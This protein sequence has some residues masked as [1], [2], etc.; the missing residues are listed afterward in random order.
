VL[1]RRSVLK[2]IGASLFTAAARD[3]QATA[4]GESRAILNEGFNWLDRAI[5]RQMIERIA[6]AGFNVLVTCVWHGTG[7]AWP[8]KVAPMIENY[9]GSDP[10]AYLLE[11]AARRGIEVHA[12]FTVAL[13]QRDFLN[14]LYDLGTP[15]QKFELHR[16]EF[17]EFICSTMLEFVHLYPVQGINLDYVRTGG[18]SLSSFAVQDYEEKTGRSLLLDRGLLTPA[19]RT[20]LQNWQEAAITEIIRNVSTGSRSLRPGILVSVDAAP[21]YQ[22]YRLEGQNSIRW[23]E[24]GL[25]D[26]LYSMNYQDVL[27]VAG[28]NAIRNAMIRP[29]ALVPVVSNYLDSRGEVKSRDGHAMASLIE[30]SRSVSRDNGVAVYLYNMLDDAQVL[31]LRNTVFARTV[32]PRWV[33]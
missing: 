20:S 7:A 29:A 2:S 31:A 24:E 16:R 8:S 22:P 30:Q 19:A 28:L 15:A 27:D 6:D 32:I 1:S 11:L 26:V 25:I 13:R 23:A 21:W 10:F 18:T 33:R 3:S 14:T 12:W 4:E 5:A 9:P 17:R